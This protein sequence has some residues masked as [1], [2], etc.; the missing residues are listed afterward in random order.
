[1]KLG[2]KILLGF[3]C[4]IGICVLLGSTAV[5]RMSDVK[6]DTSVLAQ[7]SMPAAAIA[8]KVEREFARTMYEMRGYSYSEETNYL[9]RARTSMAQLAKSLESAR[10]MASKPGVKTLGSLKEAAELAAAKAAEYEKLSQDTLGIIEGLNR[11]RQLMDEAAQA[12]MKQASDF[13]GIQNETLKEHLRTNQSASVSVLEDRVLK[14]N[15]VYDVLMLGQEIQ[16]G[17]FKAQ[18]TRNL[19]HLQEAQQKFPQVYQKLDELKGITRQETNLKQIEECRAAGQRYSNAMASLLAHW[20]ER[21]QINQRRVVV[22]NAGL[23]QAQQAASNSMDSSSKSSSE[24]ASLL[25]NASRVVIIGLV[26]ALL[27][28]AGLALV[29]TRSITRP[30]R[31]V[32]EQL[33]SGAEQTVSAAEQVSSASQS[34]AEGASEQAASLEETSSSLEEMASM[35]QRNGDNTQRSNDLAKEARLAAERGASDM[36][37]MSTAMDAIKA[38]SDEIAKIIRTID[39]IAFQTNLLALNAAVEAAR[40]G[41]AGMGF[42]VVAEEVRNL[43][44]RSAVAAKETSQKIEGAI[45]KSALG[46]EISAR[47]ASAL[48]DI[49]TKSEAG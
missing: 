39:E 13:L 38:S 43:A 10:D 37:T 46:V 26:I 3:G 27:V 8:N 18:S 31:R 15:L 17:N 4:L 47:V 19:N 29:I 5:W 25:T 11:D 28:G 32:A 16:I 14:I 20:Q 30:V 1:M 12:Y 21:D 7:E 45:Q 36:Q 2:T 49:L 6:K 41:E 9:A 33:S 40:A 42:A 22:G 23:Q 24:A 34:L 48:N 44:Q 35:T